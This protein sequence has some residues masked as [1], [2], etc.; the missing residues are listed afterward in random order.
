MKEHMGRMSKMEETLEQKNRSEPAQSNFSPNQSSFI[1]RGRGRGFSN[2]GYNRGACR[3]DYGQ[4]HNNNYSHNYFDSENQNQTGYQG[5]GYRGS[6]FRGGHRGGT[7]T[8]GVGRGGRAP[9]D[10]SSLNE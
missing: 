5:N 6:G 7:S 3:G 10:T 4:G 9:G 1:P 8:R 2:S